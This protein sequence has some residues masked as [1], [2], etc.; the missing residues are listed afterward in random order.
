MEC[1]PTWK[2]TLPCPVFDVLAFFEDGVDPR[3]LDG[4]CF[5]RWPRRSS[6]ERRFGSNSHEPRSGVTEGIGEGFANSIV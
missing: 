3:L 4:E 5:H 1:D 2:F 6:G